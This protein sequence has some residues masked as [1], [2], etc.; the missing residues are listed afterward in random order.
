MGRSRKIP[1]AEHD[2][3][4]QPIDVFISSSQREF[5]TLRKNLKREIEDQKQGGQWIFR[6]ELAED[7]PGENVDADIE[8]LLGRCSIYVL[9][10]GRWRSTRT[11]REFKYASSRG[12]PMLVYE[13]YPNSSKFPDKKIPI[14]LSKAKALGIKIRGH[15]ERFLDRQDLINRV[16][17]DL[18]ETIGRVV[19]HYAKIR[20]FVYYEKSSNT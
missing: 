17:V 20:R 8:E 6:A 10:I 9:I 4:T 14:I 3:I 15:D 11:A 5:R 12:I 1:R 16:L 19:N 18:P 2:R 7:Y 13:Y